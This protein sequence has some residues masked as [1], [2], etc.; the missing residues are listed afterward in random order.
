MNRSGLTLIEFIL[1]IAII[2]I[3]ALNVFPMFMD[4]GDD[5]ETSSRVGLVGAIRTGISFYQVND[6]IA[7]EQNFGLYP[8]V[9]DTENDGPCQSCFSEI[10]ISGIEDSSWA[11]VN[12]TQ[13]TYNDGSNVTTYNYNNV[14][15]EFVVE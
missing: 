15:G 14:T 7:S 3:L 2:A 4:V 11:R 8:A 13:Y 1:M 9:L 5:A 12:D 10:F 6:M